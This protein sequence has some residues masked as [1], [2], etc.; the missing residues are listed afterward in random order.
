MNIYQQISYIIIRITLQCLEDSQ[1]YYKGSSEF[2]LDTYIDTSLCLAE[3]Q[4][5]IYNSL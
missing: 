3:G 5:R 1:Q 2:D 4:N